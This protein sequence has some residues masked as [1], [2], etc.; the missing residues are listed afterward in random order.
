M[1]KLL[2]FVFA[3]V[4]MW[5]P[6]M[7]ITAQ[8][9]KSN[10]VEV[11]QLEKLK[12]FEQ[13]SKAQDS[14]LELLDK[15]KPTKPIIKIIKEKSRVDTLLVKGTTIVTPVETLPDTYYLVTDSTIKKKLTL[16]Q[17]IF[18]RKKKK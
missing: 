10:P 5:Q 18:G 11:K 16:W 2:V 8:A 7:K 6:P 12:L 9:T 17:K 13:V 14:T 3:W 4:I 15:K 1:K